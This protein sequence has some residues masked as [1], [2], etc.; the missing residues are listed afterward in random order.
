MLMNFD[1]IQELGKHQVE[2]VTS[3]T[4]STAKGLRAIAAEAADY[5]KKSVDNSR[6]YVEKLLRIQNLDDIVQLQA[7]FAKK[8]CGDF[9]ARATKVGELYS[10]LAKDA[11]VSAQNVTETTGKAASETT[12][13]VL[14]AAKQ[15]GEQVASR[16]QAAAK[17]S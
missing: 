2:A 1:E 17:Q 14:S 9:I 11:F 13:K 7:D 5:S 3:A 10:D 15:Q 12:S 4:A 16:V 8:T 6:V